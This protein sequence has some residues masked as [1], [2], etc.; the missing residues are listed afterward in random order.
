MATRDR[1]ALLGHSHGATMVYHYVTHS[2]RFCAAI[3]VNGRVDWVMQAGHPRDGLL[4]GPLGASPDERPDLYA[5]ASPLP[6]LGRLST[7]LLGVAGAGDGQILPENL[8]RLAEEARRL[9]KPV[10]TI[11]F[12]EAD[13]WIN[14]ATDRDSLLDATRRVLAEGCG[15]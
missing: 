9:G 15:R 7:P 4:P 8:T 14:A 5:A 1:V 10:T 6:N 12:E 11:L 2:D 3:A 13:H